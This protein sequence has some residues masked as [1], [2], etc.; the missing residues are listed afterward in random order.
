FMAAK[1]LERLADHAVNVAEW[2][3]FLKTGVHKSRRIV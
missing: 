2:V 1:Y 3:G